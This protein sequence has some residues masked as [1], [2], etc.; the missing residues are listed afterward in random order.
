MTTHP[1][2]GPAAFIDL[3]SDTERV[4]GPLYHR[5]ALLSLTLPVVPSCSRADLG[6]LAPGGVKHHEGVL[7]TG[8]AYQPVQLVMVQRFHGA[9][10]GPQVPQLPLCLLGGRLHYV[11]RVQPTLLG[12]GVLQPGTLDFEL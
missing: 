10:A 11:A 12:R 2:H 7:V 3:P 1:P 8:A 5:T 9:G 4:I 6:E